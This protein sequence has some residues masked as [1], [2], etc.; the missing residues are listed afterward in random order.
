M[1]LAFEFSKLSER[2][3]LAYSC[4]S[5]PIKDSTIDVLLSSLTVRRQQ[6]WLLNTQVVKLDSLYPSCLFLSLV[7]EVE[8]RALPV[9]GKDLTTKLHSQA[10]SWVSTILQQDTRG[11]KPSDMST[12]CLKSSQTCLLRCFIF[13][14]L[15]RGTRVCRTVLSWVT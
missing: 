14:V 8:I 11:R 15:P 7:L 4:E 2:L 13:S 12:T 10:F 3:Y 1:G 9:L 6:A 5:L